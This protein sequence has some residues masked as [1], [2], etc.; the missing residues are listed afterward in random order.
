MAGNQ[1]RLMIVDDSEIDREIL[2]EIL[3]DDFSV[4]KVSSGFAAM[5]MLVNKSE[6]LDGLLLDVSMPVMDGFMVLQMMEENNITDIPV[7]MIT[8]EGTKDNIIKAARYNVKNFIVKPFDSKEV[9]QRLRTFFNIAAA[10]VTPNAQDS[11]EYRQDAYSD[12]QTYI[13]TLQKVYIG[14]LKNNGRDY[15]HYERVTNL[16]KILMSQYVITEKLRDINN[17]NIDVISKASFFIDIGEMTIPDKI[18]AMDNRSM[19]DESTYRKHTEL[20]GKIISMNRSSSCRYFVRVCSDMCIH[21]HERYNGTGYPH[22]LK[23]QE[24]SDITQI[25]RIA[26]LF[27]SIFFSFPTQGD[28]QFDTAISQI[29]AD[30]GSC[31]PTLVNLTRNCKANIMIYYKKLAITSKIRM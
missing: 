1:K 21:H 24:N 15:S 17:D 10:P 26:D 11:G 2:E 14:Y 28:E 27:D 3:K 30:E 9:L 6:K 23:Y 31:K 29:A 4:V 20:G 25:V 8:A 19:N 7:F 12:M 16:V 5:E 22:G 18:V 13:R